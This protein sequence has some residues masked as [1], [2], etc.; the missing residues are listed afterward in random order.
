MK[1]LNYTKIFILTLAIIFVGVVVFFL[2]TRDEPDLTADELSRSGLS[3]VDNDLVKRST[4]E[5]DGFLELADVEKAIVFEIKDK[6]DLVNLDPLF[7]RAYQKDIVI[8]LPNQTIIYDASTKTI[9]DISS[10]SFYE[11]VNK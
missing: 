10:K 1:N 5:V 9:R 2:L 3:D 11:L 4:S 7:N 8:F 6:E